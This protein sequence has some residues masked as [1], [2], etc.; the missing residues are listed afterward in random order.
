MFANFFM[1]KYIFLYILLIINI[2]TK[3][4]IGYKFA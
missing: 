4:R 2:L 3:N 1:K